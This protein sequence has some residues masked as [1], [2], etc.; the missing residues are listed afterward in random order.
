[1]SWYLCVSGLNNER[2]EC[3]VISIEEGGNLKI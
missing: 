1:M 2:R 3:V